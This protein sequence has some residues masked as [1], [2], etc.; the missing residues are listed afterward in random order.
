MIEITR[1][2]R[3]RAG[4]NKTPNYWL[5][6][7]RI[8]FRVNGKHYSIQTVWEYSEATTTLTCKET[9]QH[10]NLSENYVDRIPEILGSWRWWINGLTYKTID[11]FFIEKILKTY[12]II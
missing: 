5:F 6:P 12:N 10:W 7:Y 3:N 2:G 11:T 8:N 4:A 9:R 1:I